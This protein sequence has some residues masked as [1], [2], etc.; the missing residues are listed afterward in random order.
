MKKILLLLLFPL[1]AFTPA[2]AQE[3]PVISFY[4]FVRG[5]WYYNSR[6]NAEAVDG[7]DCLYP[8]PPRLDAAGKDLNKTPNSN[9][10]MVST[11]I[12]FDLQAIKIGN[13]LTSAKIEADFSG[14]GD[15]SK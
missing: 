1:L 12:G 10:G 3:K 9:F 4:G 15:R 7:I 2:D 6:K 8:M 5:D 11:R 13:V 14:T